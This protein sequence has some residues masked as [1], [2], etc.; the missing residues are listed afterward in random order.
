MSFF[1]TKQSL[2]PPV[3]FFGKISWSPLLFCVSLYFFCLIKLSLLVFAECFFTVD[4]RICTLYEMTIRGDQAFFVCEQKRCPTF[5]NRR[6][7]SPTSLTLPLALFR[8]S[9]L[10]R[11]LL[12]TIYTPHTHIACVAAA[13]KTC[14]YFRPTRTRRSAPKTETERSSSVG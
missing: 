9:C 2:V 4:K 1:R 6:P 10:C 5:N 12:K 8:R 3:V 14:R 11:I 7:N 13:K